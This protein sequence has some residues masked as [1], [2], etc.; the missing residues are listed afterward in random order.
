[1]K[2]IKDI[3]LLLIH[4]TKGEGVYERIIEE[5]K[6]FAFQPN[7]L[8]KC[9]DVNILLSLV[10]SGVGASILPKTA[11]PIF[12]NEDVKVLDI[13]DSSLQAETA[14]IWLENRYIS[15]AARSFI[16]GFN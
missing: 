16:E 2:E 12:V 14:L 15:K 8:C 3:P 5:C 13:L 9:T 4:R 7:V 11:I 1:M 6:R 10:A